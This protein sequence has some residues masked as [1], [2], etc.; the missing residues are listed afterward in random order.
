MARKKK[1]FMGEGGV[2]K[3]LKVFKVITVLIS[4]NGLND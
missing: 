2:L 1:R 4:P 3:V